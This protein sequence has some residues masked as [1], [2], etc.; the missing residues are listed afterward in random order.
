M[1]LWCQLL[2]QSDIQLN[3]QRQSSITPNISAYTHVHSPHNFMHKSLAPLGC[4]I[5]AHENPYKRGNWADHAINAW[6]LGTSMEHHR[7]LNVYSKHTAAEIIVDTLL[8]KHKYLT[9]PIVT[10]EDTVVEA[11][12]ILTYAVTAN[13][14]VT[15]LNKR[16]R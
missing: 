10:L 13:S 9:S 11:A 5:L 2:P 15:I 12:K 4:P 6:N 8:F 3:I 16:K 7:A 14:K 1:H